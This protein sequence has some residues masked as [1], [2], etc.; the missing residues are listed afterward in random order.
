MDM[1]VDVILAEA[2]VA[3]AAGAIPE[4][5][6]WIVR[7]RPAADRT[8]M[9]VE[10]VLLLA[11]DPRG[12]AAE[13]HRARRRTARNGAQE[14]AAAEHEEVQHRHDREQVYRERGRDHAHDKESGVHQRKP[15]HL[16]GKDEEQQHLHIREHR[17]EGK[18]HGQIHI[19]RVELDADPGDEI[20]QKAIQQRQDDAGEKVNVELRN[21][22]KTR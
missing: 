22:N 6:V 10:P 3:G 4:F 18:E 2:V 12:G 1:V 17:R 9:R 13:V 5:Q 11:P 7:I 14:L 20:D 19:L 21:R 16:D 8:F 15:F